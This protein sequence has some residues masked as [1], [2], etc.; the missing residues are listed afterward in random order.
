[1]NWL[2]NILRSD[3]S[4]AATASPMPYTTEYKGVSDFLRHAPEEKKIEVFTEAARRAS[5][6]QKRT[7]KKAGVS[8]V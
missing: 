2:M 8:L 5:E 3:R 4:E 1:M 7:L 6:D